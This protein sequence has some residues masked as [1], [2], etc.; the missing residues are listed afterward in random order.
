MTKSTVPIASFTVKSETTS[1]SVALLLSLSRIVPRPL[2]S[3]I[4]TNGLE[5]FEISISKVSSDSKIRSSAI[6][7]RTTWVKPETVFCG[8]TTAVSC[9][10]TE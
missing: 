5:T 2:L 10:R 3:I 7:K 8:K 6:L 4:A 9:V 1:P